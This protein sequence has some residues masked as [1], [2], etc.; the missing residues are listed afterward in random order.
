MYTIFLHN[1]ACRQGY[2][3]TNQHWLNLVISE[4]YASPPSATAIPSS[5]VLFA[6]DAKQRHN[7]HETIFASSRFQKNRFFVIST[8]LSFAVLTDHTSLLIIFLKSIAG[9]PDVFK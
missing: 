8:T 7:T 9:A 1:L 2:C 5:I 3:C 6:N 4:G